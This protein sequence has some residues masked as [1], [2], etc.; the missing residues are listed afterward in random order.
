MRKQENECK[1]C[2]KERKEN[3]PTNKEFLNLKIEKTN[4]ICSLCED[5]VRLNESKPIVVACCEGACLRGEIARKVANLLC[6]SLLPDR[7]VRLCLGSALTK[8]GGQR[9]LVEN[10]RK[11]LVL[12]GCPVDC[13]SRLI[14]GLPFENNPDIIRTDVLADFDKNL[15]GINEL[16]EEII[17]NIALS[18]AKQIIARLEF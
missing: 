13:G 16:S 12:E 1:V 6:H 14:G 2:T 10:A 17:N 7:T 11:I 3:K 9:S 15:F 5:Y 4:N 18:V 8:E